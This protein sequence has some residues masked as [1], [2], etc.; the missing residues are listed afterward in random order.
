ME[1]ANPTGLPSPQHQ[2]KRGVTSSLRNAFFIRQFIGGASFYM[3]QLNA[4]GYEGY[5]ASIL[6]RRRQERSEGKE[7]TLYE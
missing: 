2:F 6:G 1:D 5:I 7:Y 3:K 4:K